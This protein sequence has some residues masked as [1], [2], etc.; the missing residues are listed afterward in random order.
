[1][2]LSHLLL[3]E[4]VETEIR[5]DM[6]E[7][8]ALL[9]NVVPNFSYD[10]Y[11]YRISS[12]KGVLGSQWRLLVKPWDRDKAIELSPTVGFIEV[13]KLESGAINFRIPPREVW[14][15]DEARAFDGDGKLFASFVFQLLNTF[16]SRGLIDL[17]GQLPIR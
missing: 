7:V 9:D 4:G 2:S 12:S 11:G 1:M 16:Q 17:P 13:D 5:A 10:S 15:D 14:G 3:E 6:N 8:I